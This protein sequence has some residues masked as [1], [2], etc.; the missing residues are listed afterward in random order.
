M[1]SRIVIIDRSHITG[2]LKISNE[3]DEFDN[4]ALT[5]HRNV[6]VDTGKVSISNLNRLTYITGGI[7]KLGDFSFED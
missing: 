1:G 3:I 7:N 5:M 4:W 6:N 2:A